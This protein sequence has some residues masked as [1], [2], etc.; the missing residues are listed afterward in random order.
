MNIIVNNRFGELHLNS[1]DLR[2]AFRAI[3]IK[4]F[5]PSPE[6]H[7]TDQ[8]YKAKVMIAVKVADKNMSDL[9]MRDPETH[10]L[11]LSTFPAIDQKI[12]V[13]VDSKKL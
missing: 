12:M 4:C 2:Q 10:H 9:G 8:S 5:F 6:L 7:R 11:K 13:V 1:Y 3:D